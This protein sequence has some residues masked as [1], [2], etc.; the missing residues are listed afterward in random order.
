MGSQRS[1]QGSVR[2]EFV[3]GA[4][5]LAANAASNKPIRSM[6]KTAMKPFYVKTRTFYRPITRQIASLTHNDD[7]QDFQLVS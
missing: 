6:H 5:A 4:A 2:N 3:L 1:K 7:S